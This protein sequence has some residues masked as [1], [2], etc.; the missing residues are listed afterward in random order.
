AVTAQLDPSSIIRLNH[1]AKECFF[2]LLSTCDLSSYDAFTESVK[3][4]VGDRS[5]D[6]IGEVL[7]KPKGHNGKRKGESHRKKS[8]PDANGM[9]VHVFPTV[10]IWH[11]LCVVF[12][13]TLD[14]LA[15]NA[16]LLI[17][18]H[19]LATTM[20]MAADVAH[21]SDTLTERDVQIASDGFSLLSKVRGKASPKDKDV[22]DKAISYVETAEQFLQAEKKLVRDL[23]IVIQVFFNKLDPSI[24]PSSPFLPEEISALFDSFQRVHETASAFTILFESKVE[25][26]VVHLGES[27]AEFVLYHEYDGYMTHMHNFKSVLDTIALLSARD[28]HVAYLEKLGLSFSFKY[29]L[30][31]LMFEPVNVVLNYSA[32]IKLLLKAQQSKAKKTAGD[33]QDAASLRTALTLISP[34]VAQASEYALQLRTTHFEPFST[35]VP[36]L[37]LNMPQKQ[38]ALQRQIIKQR[39][40]GVLDVTT[41]EV[42]A[43]SK[44]LL[45]GDAVNVCSV[46]GASEGKLKRGKPRACMVYS[47][48]TGVVVVKGIDESEA[49]ASVLHLISNDSV[50]IYRGDERV[51]SERFVIYMNITKAPIG[52]ELSVNPPVQWNIISQSPLYCW[53]ALQQCVEGTACP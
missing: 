4:L 16:L 3:E 47:L 8:L 15:V 36:P 20:G 12:G 7:K 37:G 29:I 51:V 50:M 24:A 44:Q 18:Q 26:R 45:W 6:E 19:V 21:S 5:F 48:D 9:P 49:K 28:T 33:V 1:L 53:Y 10:Q 52:K 2:N 22:S 42:V 31:V 46:N 27:F 38:K 40:G 14:Q 17:L 35:I 39:L 41:A 13:E 32:V 25:Q 11:R 43:E 34:Q 30:P 23:D